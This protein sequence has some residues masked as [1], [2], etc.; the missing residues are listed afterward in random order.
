MEESRPGRE[1]GGRIL[2][3]DPGRVR[4]GLA[5]SDPEGLLA[6]PL[7]TVSLPPRKLVDHVLALIERHDVCLVLIGQPR[8]PSGDPGEIAALSADLARRIRARARVPVL[9]RDESLTS[10]EA[11]ALIHRDRERPRGPGSARSRKAAKERVDRT[12]AA[13]ILQDYLDEAR[14]AGRAEEERDDR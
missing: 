4:T 12:A 1:A 8:L 10:W 9:L 7:E 14:R 5:L 11:G 13:L 6:S 2:A 3:L